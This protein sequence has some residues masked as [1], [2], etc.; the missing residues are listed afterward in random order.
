MVQFWVVS[1]RQ[2]RVQHCGHMSRRKSA[3]T[4][5]AR[6][7]KLDAEAQAVIATMQAIPVDIQPI[8]PEKI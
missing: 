7:A 1:R 8:Y 6:Y 4:V 2:G 3:Q 5:Y